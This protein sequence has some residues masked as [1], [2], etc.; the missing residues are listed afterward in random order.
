M[1]RLLLASAVQDAL[2]R[3]LCTRWSLHDVARRLVGQGR[4]G[5]AVFR[6]VVDGPDA[7]G[8]AVG[9]DAE[10]VLANALAVFV[11]PPMAVNTRFA[12]LVTG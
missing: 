11:L 1:F 8:P 6:A 5:A 12:C 4:P 10:L 7:E 3:R 9:S 2:N